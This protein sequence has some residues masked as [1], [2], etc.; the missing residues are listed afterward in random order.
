MSV[1]T[2]ISKRAG[3]VAVAYDA[4]DVLVVPFPFTNRAAEKRRP[5]VVLTLRAANAQTGHSVCAMITSADNA[6]WPHD[7]QLTDLP[8]AGLPSPSVI[9][10]KWFTIDNRLI[11][12]R[13]GALAFRDRRSLTHLVR[14]VLGHS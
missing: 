11:L 7:I 6:P 1:P 13:A 12:R 3:A 8:S 14:G 2:R 10:L 5:A 4:F 9:R